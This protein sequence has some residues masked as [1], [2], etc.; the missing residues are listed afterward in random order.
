MSTRVVIGG[1]GAAVGFVVGGGPQGAMWGWQIGSMIGNVVDPQIIKGPS[2]GDVSQQTS[3]EGIPIPITYGLSPPI[4]GNI[5]AAA[6]PNIVRS[7][8]SGKGGP[9]Y[10]TETIYRT[11]AINFCEGPI[12]GF[13]RVWRNNVK[14]YDIDDPV[15]NLGIDFSDVID[16]AVIESRNTKFLQKA[17]FFLGTYSQA[18]STDLEAV[19]GVGATPAH[20]GIAYMVIVD[21]DTTAEGGI[22]PYWQAQVD[23]TA[24][25][26]LTNPT[27]LGVQD[28][29][30]PV[31]IGAVTSQVSG[32][33]Y[34]VVGLGS[35]LVG[36][37]AAQIKAGQKANGAAAIAA[38]DSSVGD[39][40]P[41][42][43]ISG[44][45]AGLLYKFA[46][47][48]ENANG[49]SNLVYGNFKE[50][51][52]P[53]LTSPVPSGELE[54]M[55]EATVGAT[56]DQ[57]AGGIY[58]VLGTGSTLTGITAAQILDGRQANGAPAQHAANDFVSSSTPTIHFEGLNVGT[59]YHYAIVQ[60]TTVGLSNVVTGEFT[61]W[62]GLAPPGEVEYTEDGTWNKPANLDYIIVTLIGAGG[63]GGSGNVTNNISNGSMTPR[64]GGGSGA[65]RRVQIYEAYLPSSMPVI[66][67][68]GGAGASANTAS[69]PGGG[70]PTVA[71]SDGTRGT[72][73]IFGDVASGAANKYFA[74]GGYDPSIG[75]NTQ[76]GAATSWTFGQ[77]VNLEVYQGSPSSGNPGLKAAGGGGG[78][79]NVSVSSGTPIPVAGGTGVNC[80]NH[81]VNGGTGGTGGTWMGGDGSVGG[82]SSDP[83]AGGGGG[84][85]GGAGIV[86]SG[87]VAGNGADGGTPGGGGGTG[88]NCLLS[89]SG[90]GSGSGTGGAGGRGGDGRVIIEH[91]YLP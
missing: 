37:T 60:Q 33:F 58:I 35:D 53:T 48:Q 84:G 21:E 70:T 76:G 31:E 82:S 10:E 89:S 86:G 43:S 80:D 66:V 42:V 24:P 90:V 28:D 51:N 7:R 78:G 18:A 56:T 91:F 36:V 49:F 83:V 87:S 40:T 45:S 12:G 41:S 14:V 8:E 79:G 61:T 59:L 1:L 62:D 77:Y 3:Q 23:A 38:E 69:P 22:I 9:K 19:F 6:P 17:R 4:A 73:S 81:A 11:Y 71:G 2:V 63:G 85:G 72:A 57:V 29:I 13:R 34:V 50:L 74:A 65:Y 52:L 64:N 55:T 46:A 20:R 54:D 39:S 15:F 32:T 67:G 47:V 5:S 26:V 16:G 30:T 75:I 68:V 27:P 25:A 44:L 88:G